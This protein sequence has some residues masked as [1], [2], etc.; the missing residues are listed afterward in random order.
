MKLPLDIS[1]QGLPHSD[2]I[3]A[4]VRRHASKLEEFCPEIMRCRVSVVLDEK[5]R[6]QGKPFSVRIDVTVPGH[7]LVSNREHD[8]DVY[9]ALRDAFKDAIRMLEDLVRKRRGQVKQHEERLAGVVVRLNRDE[10]YGFIQDADQNDYY[11]GP[12]NLTDMAFEHLEIGTPVHFIAEIAAEG[13]QAN[14]ISKAAR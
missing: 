3:E 6:H 7:E 12:E 8:E 11:F 10:R 1:F 4:A 2:A 9:V 14:R 5:H 13:R